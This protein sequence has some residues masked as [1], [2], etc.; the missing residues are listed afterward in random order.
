MK[1]RISLWA[2]AGVAV[3]A[4]WMLYAFIAAPAAW[5]SPILWRL[6]EASC[7]IA[8]VGRS[9]P[10]AFYWIAPIN[11]ATY[12]LFGLAFELARRLPL[13]HPSH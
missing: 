1:R 11:A 9:T 7:P 5:N 6:A 13:L 2:L 3:A 8:I 10:L 4:S 12:A